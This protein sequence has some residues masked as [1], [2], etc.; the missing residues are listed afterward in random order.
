MRTST[1]NQYNDKSP[2][3]GIE[4]HGTKLRII[5]YY[6]KVKCNESLDLEYTP[7]NVKIATQK[8]NDVI[9]DIRRGKF[10]YVEHFPNS[11]RAKLFD[12]KEKSYYVKD[13]LEEQITFYTSSKK[14]ADNT[15]RDYVRYIKN[16][17]IPAFGKYNIDELTPLVIKDWIVHSTQTSK[18]VSNMIIPFRAMLDDAK[19]I[20]LISENPLD[21]LSLRRLFQCFDDHSDYEVEPFNTQEKKLILNYDYSQQVLNLVKFGFYSGLRIGE[22]LALQWSHFDVT[23]RRIKVEF[24]LVNQKLHRPK[25]KNSIR[26]LTLLDN[27]YQA[28]IDQMKFT[29][30]HSQFIFNNPNT[31]NMW[32]STDAFRKHWV[33]LLEMAKIKYRNPY[34]MRHTFASMMLSR[35]ENSLKVAKYLGHK[36]TE[37]VTKIYGKYIPID[38]SEENCFIG[39]YDNE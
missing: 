39:N 22:I 24:T 32:L 15:V 36:D 33:K 1:K 35:G 34:Q 26:E 16:E 4:I 6:K 18:Y 30:K 8:R 17:L 38:E 19:N 11:K 14:Y 13:L 29:K 28:I 21:R 10:N 2:A 23:T 25:T 3:T 12:V 7:Q 5:F 37:M 31:E 9:S 20:G 27:A